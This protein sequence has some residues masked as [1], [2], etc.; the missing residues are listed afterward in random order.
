MSERTH[1]S[2]S[3]SSVPTRISS[4]AVPAGSRIRNTYRLSEYVGMLA[5]LG[6]LIFFFSLVSDH[7]F[8]RITFTT[9]ANQ[10]PALT[11]IAVGMTFVLIIAGIDLSVGSVMA[12]SAGVLGV[13]LTA[14]GW[15]LG[16]AVVACLGVGLLAGAANGLITVRWAVPS[17]I[18]TLGMLEIAR[19][20]AYLVTGSRSLFIGARV[21]S[22]GSPLPGL[23]LSPAFL[24]AVLVVLVGQLVLSRT[25]FGRYMVAIGTN[26]E[27]VRLSGVDPRPVQVVVFM[28][29]GLLAGLGGVF[30]VAY[31]E[32]ADPNAGIG[33]ELAAIAAVV[34]GGTSLMGGRGSVINTFFGVLI[35]AVLQTGLAQMGATEPAKRVVTGGV[36]VAAVILDA[37]RHRLAGQRYPLLERL[38]RRRA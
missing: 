31:L 17:F 34:I 22:I 21:E 38:L 11:V 4:E 20:G 8:T 27:A 12:L 1:R 10:I 23:G 30:H 37:Y 35:I 33:L 13:V 16:L 36:I 28:L 29:A 26:T 3:R 19:G 14:W 25:I 9:L 18:V 24:F 32:A 15:P 6:L 5:V 7:F 2:A